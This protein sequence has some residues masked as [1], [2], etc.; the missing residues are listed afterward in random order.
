MLG[1]LLKCTSKRWQTSLGPSWKGS[2][3]R[4]S[5][6]FKGSI[7][8]NYCP[9]FIIFYLI[10]FEMFDS[11][12]PM[13]GHQRHLT[14]STYPRSPLKFVPFRRI[15]QTVDNSVTVELGNKVL[16]NASGGGAKGIAW[17]EMFTMI[18]KS[19]SVQ[20]RNLR[21]FDVGISERSTSKSKSVQL[22]NLRAVDVEISE[23]ST[24][25]AFW[26]LGVRTSTAIAFKSL[27]SQSCRNFER[28]KIAD[29][30]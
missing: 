10:P 12:T 21:A 6:K 27:K 15:H 26:K 3:S 8:S 22:R 28:F 7:V 9:A 18:S 30:R 11:L 23:R 4:L 29:E 5:R 20:R 17:F 19:L 1:N 25:N 13:Q 2:A 24:S 16:V 14:K